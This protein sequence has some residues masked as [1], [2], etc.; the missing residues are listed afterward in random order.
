MR[1]SISHI[2]FF[3]WFK[4]TFISSCLSS[5]QSISYASRL[6]ENLFLFLR[7]ISYIV[8]SVVYYKTINVWC[9]FMCVCVFLMT[10]PPGLYECGML[11]IF[12]DKVFH[13]NESIFASHYP[14]SSNA[15]LKYLRVYLQTRFFIW[16]R[17][18]WDSAQLLNITHLHEC[19]VIR[20]EGK[21]DDNTC[22]EWF[23]FAGEY[24]VAQKIWIQENNMAHENKIYLQISSWNLCKLLYI[25]LSVKLSIKWQSFDFK[26]NMYKR[27]KSSQVFFSSRGMIVNK[28]KN[29]EEMKP[30]IEPK[31]SPKK[32]HYYLSRVFNDW[33][34]H[35]ICFAT[36]GAKFKSSTNITYSI[37]HIAKK[38]GSKISKNEESISVWN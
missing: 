12:C 29:Y 7:N 15:L 10:F 38:N 28:Q 19:N 20:A 4:R 3:K 36:V 32:H 17:M 18:K 24:D 26:I 30:I 5:E 27:S 35:E 34:Q 8:Y 2:G 37:K 21:S 14:F 6:D 11:W 1:T 9:V 25:F 23:L 13:S 22:S 16:Q 33:I 31:K